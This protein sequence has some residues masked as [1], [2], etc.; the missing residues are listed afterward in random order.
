MP[1]GITYY[2]ASRHTLRDIDTVRQLLH[3]RAGA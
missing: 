1:T 2:A 3:E